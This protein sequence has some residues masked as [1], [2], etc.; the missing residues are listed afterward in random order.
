MAIRT[1][2]AAGDDLPAIFAIYEH[3]VATSTCTYQL[4]PDSEEGRLRWWHEH[5]GRYPVLVA[6]ADGVVVAW[7]CLSRHS[8]RGGYRFTVEDSIYVLPEHQGRGVGRALLAELLD[9]GRRCGF[10]VVVA[11]IEAGQA[12]SLRL[13]AALGFVEV[14]RL[15]EVGHK[16]GRWLD[17]VYM[18]IT[19]DAIAD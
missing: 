8:P 9:R 11:K 17:S 1:R 5:A 10:H 18:Q 13:H 16:F 19:L 6:E 2:D 7:A 3:Y 15:R 4:E 14:G 12:A